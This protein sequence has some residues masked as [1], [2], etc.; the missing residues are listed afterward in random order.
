MPAMIYADFSG[1]CTTQTAATLTTLTSVTD[2]NAFQFAVSSISGTTPAVKVYPSFD[3]VNFETAALA[4]VDLGAAA[5]NTALAGSVG[6]T[7]VGNYAV[8]GVNKYRSLRFDYTASVAGSCAIR[9]CFW[10]K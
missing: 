8:A 5:L 2:Y 4:L 1:T 10:K 9:G 7:A 3:G 6:A